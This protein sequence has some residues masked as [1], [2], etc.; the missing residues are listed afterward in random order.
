MHVHEKKKYSGQTKKKNKK[1]EIACPWTKVDGHQKKKGQMHVHEQKWT[2]I[3]KKKKID[4][5]V[6]LSHVGKSIP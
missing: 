3:K 6:T 2:D 4:D 5:E 1:R